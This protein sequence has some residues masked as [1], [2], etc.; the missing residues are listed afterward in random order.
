MGNVRLKSSAEAEALCECAGS[1]CTYRHA[2]KQ[3]CDFH[4]PNDRKGASRPVPAH[5]LKMSHFANYS[6]AKCPRCVI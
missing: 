5:Y 3:E 4:Q 1:V 2:L 6:A